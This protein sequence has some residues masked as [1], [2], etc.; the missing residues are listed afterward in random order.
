VAKPRRPA[1]WRR[2][3]KI[4]PAGRRRRKIRPDA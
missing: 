1:G 2:S 3:K 4:R